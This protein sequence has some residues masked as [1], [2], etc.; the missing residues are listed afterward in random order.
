MTDIGIY[1]QLPLRERTFSTAV[2]L[3]QRFDDEVEGRAFPE[4]Q[5]EFRIGSHVLMFIVTEVE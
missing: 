3:L 1:R 4:L 5:M 2:L